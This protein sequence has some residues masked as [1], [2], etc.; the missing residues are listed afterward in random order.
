MIVHRNDLDK[1]IEGNYFITAEFIIFFQW[2]FINRNR[3]LLMEILTFLQENVN[4]SEL[5]IEMTNPL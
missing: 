5:Y 1:L 3:K 2:L 4:S